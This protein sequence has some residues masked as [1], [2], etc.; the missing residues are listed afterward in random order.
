VETA[1]ESVWSHIKDTARDYVAR[2]V[3]LNERDAEAI[4]TKFLREAR[5]SPWPSIDVIEFYAQ[6]LLNMV[7]RDRPTAQ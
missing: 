7:D 3:K 5:V 2:G 1:V 4:I 6:E